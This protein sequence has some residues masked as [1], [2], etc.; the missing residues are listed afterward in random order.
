RAVLERLVPIESEVRSHSGRWY[1]RRT[2][3][4]RTADNRIDGVV[5]TFVDISAL[6]GAQQEL[7]AAQQR[8]GLVIEQMPTPMLIIDAGGHLT[9]A[10]RRAA[11]LLGQPFPVPGIGAPWQL[12]FAGVQTLRPDGS[13][14]EARD[15]PISRALEGSSVS[16]EE[17]VVVRDRDDRR[18]VL[19]SCSPLRGPAGQV[20]EVVT[21]LGEAAAG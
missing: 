2:L 21:V 16:N 12:A 19:V 3:P 1:L 5:I 14:L 7:I 15:W 8:L 11:D 17:L 13:K 4:Y 10:N 20:T 18:K 6:R 9:V